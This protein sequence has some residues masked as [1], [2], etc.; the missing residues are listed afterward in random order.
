MMN[1]TT[2]STPSRVSARLQKSPDSIT[3]SLYQINESVNPLLEA[4]D[5]WQREEE[6]LKNASISS[7]NKEI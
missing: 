3:S 7:V 4:I 5:I 1:N 6:H 2:F